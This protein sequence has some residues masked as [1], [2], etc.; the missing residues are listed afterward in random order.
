MSS[1][2]VETAAAEMADAPPGFLD[3]P[4]VS[5]FF[6]AA[7]LG[8]LFLVGLD[9]GNGYYAMLGVDPWPSQVLA[10]ALIYSSSL[11]AILGC[12]EMGHWLVS[13]AHGV[14]TSLPAFIPMPAALGTLG[15]VIAMRELPPETRPN[16][17]AT[18]P[19]RETRNRVPVSCGNPV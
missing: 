2:E 4:W 5:P 6:F 17:R 13:R 12:H 15:A 1:V 10:Q 7:T 19:C 3:R 14:R 9:N 8:S 16:R 18:E 11:I